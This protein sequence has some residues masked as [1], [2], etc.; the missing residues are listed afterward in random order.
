MPSRN[1]AIVLAALAALGLTLL[2]IPVRTRLVLDRARIVADGRSTVR[3]S[4][5]SLGPLGVRTPWRSRESPRVS[6][7]ALDA[8][9]ATL[10]LAHDGSVVLRSGQRAGRL[11]VELPSE[12]AVIELVLDAGDRDRDGL[13]DA[14]EIWSETD[15]AAFTAWFTAIAEAQA[16]RIDDAWAPIHQDC[17][18]LVR[19]AFREALKRHDRAWFEHRRYLPAIDAPDVQ[20]VRYP[21]LPFIGER[22]FRKVAGAFD[23]TVAIADQLTAAPSA[24]TLWQLNTVFVS[25]EVREARAG[26]LLFFTVPYATGSRMHTMLALGARAGSTHD[27]PAERVVYHTGT[28]VPEGGARAVEQV[29]L[30]TFAELARHPDPGWHPIADNPRFLGVHRLIHVDPGLLRSLTSRGGGPIR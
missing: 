9:G 25:R 27:A 30:V 24:R 22:P 5:V 12:R 20:A 15:R 28:E 8:L 16:T 2:M 4:V 21:D 11:A 10:L 29:R 18:G 1:G 17:A 23:P 19:F 14:A 13:P 7:A 26:D 6:Q 3:I